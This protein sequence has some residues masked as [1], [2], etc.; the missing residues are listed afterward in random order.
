MNAD[1]LRLDE[2]LESVADGRP[3]D[4][5]ALAAS[6]DARG[7]R[8]LGH[9]RLV[10]AVAEVHR[11]L[12]IDEP[13]STYGASVLDEPGAGTRRWGHLGLLEKIG[14][15]TFAEVYRAR[16]A[17]LEREVA[18]KLLKPPTTGRAIPALRI[19]NEARTLARVRHPNV[20]T[21]HGADMHEGRAGLWMELV[22]GRTLAKILADQGPFSAAE[23]TAIGQ[24]MCRALA[25]VH[26]EGLLHRDIK[27]QNVMREAGGRIVLMDFGAGHTLLYLAPEILAGGESTRA[28][29]LYALGVLLYHLVTGHFPVRGA[30][31]EELRIAHEH[32]QRQRLA[33]LR[34]DLPDRFVAAVERAIDPAPPRRFT[35]A[36]EMQEA[37]A[38][39][40]IPAA[41]P[42]PVAQGAARTA[43]PLDRRILVAATG[44][45]LILALASAAL[46]RWVGPARPDPDGIRLVA[47][48]PLRSDAAEAYFADGMTET[49]M[50]ALAGMRA[51]RVV[52]RTSV[53]RARAS[54]GTLPE[55]AHALGADAILEGS[56]H[57]TADTVRVNL[58]LIHAGSDT[59]LWS[60]S[61]EE[62][63]G[64]IFELQARVAR[65]VAEELTAAVGPLVANARQIVDPAAYDAYLRGRYEFRRRTQAGVEAALKHFEHATR[66]EPRYARAVAGIAECYLD[67]GSSYVVLP[68]AL[69]AR[70]AKEAATRAIELDGTLADAFATRAAIRFE[71]DWDFGGAEAEFLKAIEL[72]PS[73]VRP[74]E[75]YA[76]FLASRGRFDEAFRQLSA[77]R[78]VDPLSASVADRTA[79][80]YYYARQFD[81][82]LGEVQRA[83]QLEPSAMS[84]Q[85]GLG[86]VLNAMGRHQEAIA[87][88]EHVA[89]EFS[90][91]PFFQA[92]IAQA[93]LALGLQDRAI[94]RIRA[95][96]SQV[97]D[98]ASRV[99]PYMLALAYA[100][101]DRDAAFTWLE[102]AYEDHGGRVLWLLVDPRVDPLRTD[103]RFGNFLQRL[104]LAP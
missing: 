98:P 52:S 33:D 40:T 104:G 100:R 63:L 32:G 4:W 24:E 99:S 2:L 90:D 36:G 29:D 10:A 17:W 65:S 25:A 6:T 55:V 69:S 42:Q 56:V 68:V 72:D 1:P 11:T 20:V 86:R 75:Q 28:D 81:R 8:T 64:H 76:M 41:Q 87:Q 94:A 61:F 26:A 78:A 54:A 91:H 27:A 67:L 14:E 102:R 48:M 103:P 89:R 57:K 84:A 59:P 73:L 22:R 19:V 31:V 45:I 88:H 77:A 34:P 9:L 51:L 97:A 21:V 38:G 101:L 83:S 79:A 44:L 35:S 12:P 16:D 58:R 92:E 5:H 93:E 30:S 46:W 15:G 18:L 49:L 95:L 13:A 71:F 39:H 74:R 47:I 96:E 37:L 23:A 82:A 3:V 80:A 53:D 66:I 50:Q 7:Q 43:F 60:R 70:L 85:V 62:P